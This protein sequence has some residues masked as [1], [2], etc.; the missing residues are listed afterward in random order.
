M[1]NK[2][3]ELDIEI[4]RVCGILET[5]A[6][7]FREDSEESKAIA[8]AAEA[9]IFMQ[10]HHGLRTAYSTYRAAGLKGLTDDQKE[11]L[12]ALGINPDDP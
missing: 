12:R 3:S 10:L 1:P 7:T 11:R 8:E 4:R 6:K 5:I 9:Y 2:T